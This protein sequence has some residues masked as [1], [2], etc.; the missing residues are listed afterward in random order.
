MFIDVHKAIR[1]THMAPRY[2]VPRE[3]VPKGDIVVNPD[4]DTADGEENLI[5]LESR[6]GEQPPSHAAIKRLTTSERR[7]SEE[8]RQDPS[9]LSS[10]PKRSSIGRRNSSAATTSDRDFRI[11]REQTPEMREHLKHLGPSNLASRPRQTRY[12]T[13]KIKPGGGS[14]AE[15]AKTASKNNGSAEPIPFLQ[16][17]PAASGGVGEG[18]LSSAGKDASDGVHAVQTG[19]GTIGTPPRHPDSPVKS[20][21]SIQ[22]VSQKAVSSS[23]GARPHSRPDSS[24]SSSSG[25]RR[26]RAFSPVK[27]GTVRSGSITENIIE[28]DGIKKVVLELTSSSEEQPDQGAG[29]ERRDE[30]KEGKASESEGTGSTS[31]GKKKRRRKRK[32][33]SKK[34]EEEPLLEEDET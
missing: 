13:I 27:K 22:A 1:R 9:L 15:L 10:S 5:D 17:P 29:G 20:M 18:L 31:G 6:D 19:Y 14:F 25:A 33:T 21:R 34:A 23:P 30:A 11:R 24:G 2:R 28:A 26:S 16:M 8:T 3:K 7:S 12:N 4:A 32:K